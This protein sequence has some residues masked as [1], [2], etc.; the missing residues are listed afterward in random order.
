M[1]T[2]SVPVASR[3]WRQVGAVAAVTLSIVFFVAGLLPVYD[4]LMDGYMNAPE[5]CPPSV[6]NEQGW[7]ADCVSHIKS[8]GPLY[9]GKEWLAASF[10]SAGMASALAWSSTRSARSR[11]ALA[12]IMAT[13]IAAWALLLVWNEAEGDRAA[14]GE[15]IQVSGMEA[16]PSHG[17]SP[18][19]P[20]T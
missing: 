10:V 16:D 19:P 6:P 1:V 4:F 14:R 11:R 8:R 3:R 20:A 17:L 13:Y 2:R 12:I 18:V 7:D 5:R 15:G 9:L